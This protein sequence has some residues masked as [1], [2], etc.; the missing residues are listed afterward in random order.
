METE[1]RSQQ[2][3][4]SS[5]TNPGKQINLE[6]LHSTRSFDGLMD[7][8]EN[9]MNDVRRMQVIEN[10]INIFKQIGL[11]CDQ[12]L[13]GQS[14]EQT[15]ISLFGK[16]VIN[17]F[18]LGV[19][20]NGIGS[21]FYVQAAVFDHS[22]DP[23]AAIVFDNSN[24]H[25]C[26]VRAIKDIRKNDEIF[27]SYISL[28]LPRD[29]RIKALKSNYYFDCICSKCSDVNYSKYDDLVI[30]T[31]ELMEKYGML[32]DGDEKEL[33]ILL[34][35][36]PI[37][38]Q[39]Y[40]QGYH[41]DF[42]IEI[43]RIVKAMKYNNLKYCTDPKKRKEKDKEYKK[44]WNKMVQNVTITHGLDHSFYTEFLESFR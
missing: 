32:S 16:V 27:I 38:L 30:K 39:M 4:D 31:D 6:K 10:M 28:R 3:L 42:T 36:Y 11:D 23:N 14:F 7:H 29:Q 44:F 5:Q 41:P 13:D 35:V 17:G 22:C 18:E 8:Y 34:Q 40:N 21:G 1:G 15:I 2:P 24:H 43:M 19:E 37:Q 20:S 33:G 9:L 12:Q 26:Q 25:R